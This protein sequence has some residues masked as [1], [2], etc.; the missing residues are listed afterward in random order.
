MC[1][2]ECPRNAITIIPDVTAVI[3]QDKCI[4]CGKCVDNCQAEAIEKIIDEK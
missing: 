2:Y 3:D 1:Y 4:R